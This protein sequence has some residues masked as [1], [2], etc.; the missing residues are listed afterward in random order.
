MYGLF[1]AS[2]SRT[3]GFDSIRKWMYDLCQASF[4][5]TIG[6]D[7]SRKWMYGL[8]QASFSRTFGFSRNRIW[9]YDL[10]QRSF[11]RYIRFNTTPD[12]LENPIQ[13]NHT[14]GSS[15]PIKFPDMKKIWKRHEKGFHLIRWKPQ[16]E[17]GL[18]L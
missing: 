15:Q 14:T 10:C 17:A 2:F 5:H 12:S 18:F 16:F 9:M 11:S 3:F 1:Q 13:W 6:I 4:S 8:C 7:R